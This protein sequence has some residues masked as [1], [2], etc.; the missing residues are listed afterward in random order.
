MTNEVLFLIQT[1]LGLA[2]VL[3]AFRL[4]LK[5]LYALVAV[6]I[7]L[8]NIFVTKTMLL[9]GLEATGGN[10]LYG[11]IFLTTDIIA[12]YYGKKAARVAVY[13]GFGAALF[14]LLMS[15]MMLRYQASA[16]DLGGAEGMVKIF[17]LAPS[18]IVASLTAYLISQLHDIWAYHMWKDYFQGRHLWVRNNLSTLV[19]QFIDTLV[20]CGLAFYVFPHLF[21]PPEQQMT[22]RVVLEIII[23]TYVF[24]ALVALLD[25]PFI[26]LSRLVVPEEV[27]QLR[28]TRGEF[29]RQMA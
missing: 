2:V 8:S 11:A 25:T 13:I 9:F 28:E 17:S 27:A 19:S 6:N 26:Y 1:V 12:E 29:S 24:K 16:S 18:V 3:V 4:G 15:Q 7:V 22:G 21:M 23:T 5:W 20:F 10:V 14:Y